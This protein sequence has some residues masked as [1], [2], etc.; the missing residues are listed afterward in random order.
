M[1]YNEIPIHIV[2]L[3]NEYVHN[4][5]FVIRSCLI[6]KLLLTISTIIYIGF[7]TNGIYKY[8]CKRELFEIL[9][10]LVK[11]KFCYTEYDKYKLKWIVYDN[12]ELRHVDL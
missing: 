6:N 8:S 4:C 7:V 9:Y 12:P 3:I 10:Y 1:N 11:Q 5:F 2:R